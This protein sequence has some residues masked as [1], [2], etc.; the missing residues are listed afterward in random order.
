MIRSFS[1]PF[2]WVSGRRSKHGPWGFVMGYLASFEML[3][4]RKHSWAHYIVQSGTIELSS[5]SFYLY[6]NTISS[7]DLPKIIEFRKSLCHYPRT[8]LQSWT[9][10]RRRRS[11]LNMTCWKFW[12]MQHWNGLPTSSRNDRL[13]PEFVGIWEIDRTDRVLILWVQLQVSFPLGVY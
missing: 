8:L 1:S 4:L 5:Y 13:E 2:F 7:G 3:H 12:G 6:G 9:R 10:E 11:Y